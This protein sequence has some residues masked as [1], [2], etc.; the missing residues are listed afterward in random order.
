MKRFISSPIFAVVF[1]FLFLTGSMVFLLASSD[2]GGSTSFAQSWEKSNDQRNS[3]YNDNYSRRSGEK[4]NGWPTNFQ[5]PIDAALSGDGPESGKAFFFKG[6][7]V[8]KYDWSRDQ[9]DPGFPR[10]IKDVFRSFPSDF[11]RGIDAAISGKGKFTGKAFFFKGDRYIQYD[12]ENQAMDEEFPRQIRGDW[13]GFPTQFTRDIDAIINGTGNN[14]NKAYFFKGNQYIRYDWVKDRMDPGYPNRIDNI[15]WTNFPEEFCENID[16]ALNGDG[17]YAGKAFFF[18]ND[19]YIR[20]DMDRD[21]MDKNYPRTIYGI[22]DGERFSD[23]VTRRDDYSSHRDDYSRRDDYY[24][25]QETPTPGKAYFFKDDEYV[26]WDWESDRVDPGYP[27]K[28]RSGWRN[29]P[30]DFYSSLD[31][32]LMGDG[33]FKGKIYFFKQGQ[34]VRYDIASKRVDPGYPKWVKGP[35]RSWPNNFPEEIDDVLCG[36]GPFKGKAYFFKDNQYIR[37]DWQMD[38]TESGYP[39]SI[40]GHWRGLSSSFCEKIDAVVNGGGPNTGK[41]YFFSGSQYIRYDL[42]KDKADSGYPKNI[43]GHWKGFP[44]NFCESID[45]ALQGQF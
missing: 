9:V 30:S 26:R 14:S 1:G 34:F 42:A 19:E 43:D 3:T 15:N 21:R 45:A 12:W 8:L 33:Q 13:N 36:E 20:Y 35:W 10:R 31:A 25:Q 16:A 22:E 4:W 17:Q 29:L 24:S 41:A 37:Y 44:P 23:N 11:Y 27:R 7:R 6:D 39:K 2:T 32:V 18:K 40:S 28:I 5:T 38:K